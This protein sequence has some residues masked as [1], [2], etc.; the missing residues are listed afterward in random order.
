MEALK[1]LKPVLQ[2][3]QKYCPFT[4]RLF[5]CFFLEDFTSRRQSFLR[6]KLWRHSMPLYLILRTKVPCV[7]GLT[8]NFEEKH[9]YSR[10]QLITRG[11]SRCLYLTFGEL[12][13]SLWRVMSSVWGYKVIIGVKIDHILTSKLWIIMSS[14]SCHSLNLR[15][16][17]EIDSF[18]LLCKMF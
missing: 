2:Q 18:C 16:G 8:C 10:M 9:H 15:K 17:E 11:W 1:I 3:F 6:F 5:L 12:S 7:K 14:V 4:G 13:C